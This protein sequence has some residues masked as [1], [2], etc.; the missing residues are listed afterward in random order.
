MYFWVW[1]AH[2]HSKVIQ[3]NIAFSNVSKELYVAKQAH[4]EDKETDPLIILCG[5]V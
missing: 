2:F 5:H 3:G 1:N 4:D